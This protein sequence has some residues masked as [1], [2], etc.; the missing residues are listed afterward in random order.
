MWTPDG[1]TVDTLTRQGWTVDGP[2]H[3]DAEVHRGWWWVPQSSARHD[4]VATDSAVA[5]IDTPARD[6][7][8]ADGLSLIHI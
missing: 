2:D 8:A 1:P 5:V 3:A 7:A 4:A 6:N